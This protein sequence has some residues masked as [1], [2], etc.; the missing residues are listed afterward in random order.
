MVLRLAAVV[1]AAITLGGCNLVVSTTPLFTAADAAGAPPLRPGVWSSA[2]PDCKFDES[3]PAASWPKCANGSI[4]SATE[5]RGVADAAKPSPYILAAGDPRIMQAAADISAGPGSPGTEASV[6]QD[7]PLY[8]YLALVPLATDAQG[9]IIK[10]EAWFIQCGP[11]PPKP[12]DGKTDSIKPED[13]ATKRPLPGMTMGG[14]MCTPKDKAAV[15]GAAGPSRAWSDQM[16][17]TRWVRD[18]DK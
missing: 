16:L 7:G 1:A 6:K 17:K 2:D 10:A 11:P 5:A 13:F 14:G 18:G 4:I 9:R 15:H 3:Q 12:K 8:F